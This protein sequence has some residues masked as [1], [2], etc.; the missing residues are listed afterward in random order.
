MLSFSRLSADLAFREHVRVR[1][2]HA[3]VNLLPSFFFNQLSTSVKLLPTI[4]VL[5]PLN[6]QKQL[7]VN[8]YTR[9][10]GFRDRCS[11]LWRDLGSLARSL[12]SRHAFGLFRFNASPLTPRLI[13]SFISVCNIVSSTIL[14]P[15]H[16]RDSYF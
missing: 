16:L 7:R 9:Q 12:I 10:Y 6:A 3:L 15:N 11:F 5:A 8:E 14:T 1:L 4:S 2:V 13:R